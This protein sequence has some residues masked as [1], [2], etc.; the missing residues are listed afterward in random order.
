MST[1]LSLRPA[2]GGDPGAG[3]EQVDQLRPGQ[4]LVVHHGDAQA[5]RELRH[6]ER[7]VHVTTVDRSW[8]GVAEG[9]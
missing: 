7:V 9:V 5:A 2:R 3:G 4:L 8:H 1:L 6:G